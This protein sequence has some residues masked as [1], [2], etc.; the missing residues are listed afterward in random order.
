[1][2]TFT[3]TLKA[4]CVI[5]DPARL[6]Q[7]L[8]NLTTNAMRHGAPPVV[9]EGRGVGNTISLTVRD[10][11]KGVPRSDQPHLFERLSPTDGH[12]GSV[13]LGLWIVKM[14]AEAHNG[15]VAYRTGASGAECTITLPL[16]G[17][18]S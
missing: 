16:D 2:A 3:L 7:M 17:H 1:V 15:E 4:D 5:A 9:I 12:Q 11:G 13:G 8:V 18:P 14:L 6:E 10:H